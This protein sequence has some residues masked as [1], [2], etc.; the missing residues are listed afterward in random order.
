M[1]INNFGNF[2]ITEVPFLPIF[3]KIYTLYHFCEK[4]QLSVKPIWR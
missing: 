3:K 1:A 2:G 4:D